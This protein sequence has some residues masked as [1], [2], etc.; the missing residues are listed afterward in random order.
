MLATSTPI[1]NLPIPGLDGLRA[2]AVIAVLIYHLELPFMFK[3]GFLGVDIFFTVSGFLITALLIKEFSYSGNISISQF[4]IRRFKRLMPVVYVLLAI[5][6]LVCAWYLPESYVK[7]RNDSLAA[8]IYLSNW[9]QIF[10]EQSYFD[11]ISRPPMLQHLWS[12]AIE[13]QFYL[14]W[15]VFVLV[16]LRVFGLIYFG[17]FTVILAIASTV[18]MAYLSIESGA[19]IDSDPSRLYFGTDTHSIGLLVGA[20]LATFF[21]PWNLQPKIGE[22][23]FKRQYL[24]NLLG[25]LS[26]LCLLIVMQYRTEMWPFLFRGGLTLFSLITGILI[27]AVVHS[28]GFTHQLFSI[29]IL[30]LIGKRSYSLYIWHWPIFMLMRPGFELPSN[31]LS[32]SL[33]R[34]TVTFL[35]SELSYRLIEEPVRSG[36]IWTSTSYKKYLYVVV[37]SFLVFGIAYTVITKRSDSKESDYQPKAHNEFHAERKKT[38]NDFSNQFVLRQPTQIHSAE[39]QQDYKQSPRVNDDHQILIFGDSVMLGIA[40]F[41]RAHIYGVSVDAKVGRQGKDGLTAVLGYKEKIP[42]NSK[43]VIHF[44]TNGFLAENHLRQI[45]DQLS[46]TKKVVLINVYA[47]RKWEFDNN[48]MLAS[49]A[50][51]YKNVSLLDWKAIADANPEFLGNDQIHPNHSGVKALVFQIKKLTGGLY[52]YQVDRQGLLIPET[53]F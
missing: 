24:I 44:G 20:M 15:P 30:Q 48:A 27:I 31:H 51:Q 5:T 28:S 25:L 7:T 18:W 6:F 46:G 36:K 14:V 9:W 45:L 40:D 43:V 52:T 22:I 39:C 16:C 38:L 12:L 32:Q 34:L 3:G 10:L 8:L 21:T 23:L 19:P 4:Y 29:K 53:C 13:E 49:L 41:M 1:K 2:L 26:L 37:G 17:L 11:S 35:V 50:S 42:E 47:P 33:L